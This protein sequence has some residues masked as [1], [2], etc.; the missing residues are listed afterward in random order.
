MGHSDLIDILKEAEFPTGFTAE[1]T[2]VASR[3]AVPKAVLR[4][5]LLLM[6]F[7]LGTNMGIKRVAVT[8]K[9][10]ESEAVLPRWTCS[11]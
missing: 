7:A 10:S 3:E 2:S 8:G 6:L 11:P 1:F 4:R 5:R 9:H